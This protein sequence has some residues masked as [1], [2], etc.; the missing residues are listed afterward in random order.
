V[1]VDVCAINCATRAAAIVAARRQTVELRARLSHV[2]VASY[3][4]G[5]SALAS[6]VSAR[7][8]AQ[9]RQGNIAT[10]AHALIGITIVASLRAADSVTARTTKPGT[11]TA[12]SDATARHASRATA[13]ARHANRGTAA[14]AAPSAHVQR[15]HLRYAA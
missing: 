1:G 11:P 7:D 4:D 9:P 3:A 10:I 2:V 15:E 12:R 13:A 5:Y 8:G 14:A 6:V